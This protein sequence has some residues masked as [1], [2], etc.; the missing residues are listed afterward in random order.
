M[1]MWDGTDPRDAK[2][3][4]KSLQLRRNERRYRRK[5]ASP[6][7]WQAILESKCRNRA[8]RVCG[9]RSSYALEAHHL[10]PRDRGGDDVPANIVGLCNECHCLVEERQPIPVRCLLAS[11]QDD[12]YAYAVEKAGEGFAE[13]VYG[14]EYER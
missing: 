13:R 8:C 12:E 5:V 6:K 11:L 9:L 4:P 7:Q 3:F 1:V 14:V 10:V 2:P